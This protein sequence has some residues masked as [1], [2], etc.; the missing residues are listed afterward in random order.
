M[1]LKKLT[2]FELAFLA[3]V[4]LIIPVIIVFQLSQPDIV[5]APEDRVQGC[6]LTP[7][8]CQYITNGAFGFDP[9]MLTERDDKWLL[10]GNCIDTAGESLGRALAIADRDGISLDIAPLLNP[11][12]CRDSIIFLKKDW[13]RSLEITDVIELN[14]FTLKEVGLPDQNPMNLIG[15]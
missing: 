7:T 15:G 13:D 8:S 3:V 12:E 6:G 1:V 2:K 9:I 11:D 4:I 10:R 14:T 5:I